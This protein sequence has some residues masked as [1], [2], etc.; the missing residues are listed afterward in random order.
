MPFFR[1]LPAAELTAIWDCLL[2]VQAPAGAVLCRRGEPGD[3]FYVVQAGELEARLGLGPQGVALRR[4]GPGDVVGEM[5]LL[6]GQPRSADV[7]ALTDTVLWAL[8]RADFEAFT[9]TSVPLLRALNRAL[10]DRLLLNTLLLEERDYGPGAVVAGL[11]F[12]PYRAVEQIGAGGMGAVFSAVHAASEEAAAVK[13]LPVAWGADPELRARLERETEALRRIDHPNVVTVLEVGEV[14]ARSGGGTYLAMEYLPH[15]LD[16]VL[17]AQYPEPLP[18]ARALALAQGIAAGLGAVHAAGLVHRDVKPSNVLLRQDGTPVLIDFG[19]VTVLAEVARERRLTA[20]N[21]IPGS[22][23]YMSPEQVAG[24]PLDGRSDLYS[25]GIV[26][27]EMLTGH[28]PFAG[29]DPLETLRAHAHLPPPPSP[30]P[31]RRP[32][33]PWCSGRC[34]SAGRSATSPP[35]RWRPPWKRPAPPSARSPAPRGAGGRRTAAGGARG[36]RPPGGAVIPSLSTRLAEPP[37]RKDV[38]LL[39]LPAFGALAR[40]LGYGALSMR[41]SQVAIDSPPQR[42]TAARQALRRPGP[43][44]LPGHRHRLPGGERR[45]GHRPP[46]PHHPPPRPGPGPGLRPGAG[47]AAA[48]GRP[49]LGPAGRRRGG[50]AGPAP[51]PPD[52]RGDAA[53]DGGRGPGRGRPRRAPRLRPDLRA[54]QPPGLRLPLRPRGHPA[55]G[56]GH[57][58]CLPPEL[59]PAPRGG[60]GGAHPG[61][62]I[63][64]DQVP[65]DDRRG[66]DLAAVF[67]GLRAIG[68]RGYVTVHQTLLPGE[69]VPDAAARHLAAIRPYLQH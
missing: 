68:W 67:E 45:P 30:P 44:R 58:Q 43:G 47:D 17:R 11:R 3:R 5:A 31:S 63:R 36:R 60:D 28:V 53:G 34:G 42:V 6:T 37:G 24:S 62:P 13:V 54:L 8:T 64:V 26:L 49:P 12:G 39:D 23:D 18:P 19:L 46:A 20:P 29:L 66:I 33:A 32:P 15:A 38:A 56:P 51:G 10:V 4:L 16:R 35:R 41:A 65:L 1:D 61:G 55:P 57:L 52:P 48:R 7:V 40:D 69:E 14:E 27:Y 25:L 21:V 9:A 59:A 22:A 2:E 50:R